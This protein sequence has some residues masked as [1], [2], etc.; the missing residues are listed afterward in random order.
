MRILILGGTGFVGRAIARA[1]LAAGHEVSCVAR[2]LAGAVAEGAQLVRVDRDDPDAL[3]TL[4]S[5]TVD[6]VVEVSSKPS[7]VRSATAALAATTPYW[8]YISS[9]SVYADESTPGQRV[10]TAPLKPAAPP[11][12]DDPSSVEDYGNRKVTCEE[13]VVA[14][15][16]PALICRAGLIVG[17]EDGT[18]RFTYWPERLARGGEIVAPGTPDALTQVIDVRDLAEWLVRSAGTRLTGTFDGVC[19]ALPIA[20]LLAA[21]AAGVGAT[22]P[23]LTWIDQRFLLDHQVVPWAGA[24]SLPLWLPL[25]M[26]GGFASR[27]VSPSVGAGLTF[28]P[29]SDTARDT[30]A[31]SR[32]ADRHPLRCGLTAAEETELLA[33]W[34]ARS[35]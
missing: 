19:P 26:Y 9:G 32:R 7:H 2:G 10:D 18:D 1:A 3:G 24:R 23:E 27:D 34:Y 12:A 29:L 6:V 31:W 25:P 15:G 28:R 33:Q 13:T 16:V 20:D 11:G 21:V 17:P 30:L 22:G 5:H 4:S 14:S 35:G 8:I